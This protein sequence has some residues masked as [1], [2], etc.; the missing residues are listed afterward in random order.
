[1]ND[2]SDSSPSADGAQDRP[3][4]R[5]FLAFSSTLVMGGGVAASYGTLVV[6]AGQYLYPRDKNVSWQFVCTI[7]RLEVGETLDYVTTTGVKV[8]IT[9]QG[10][11][12]TVDDFVALSSTCPHLGCQVHWEPQN[13]RFFCPCHN[14]A[15]DKEGNPTAGPP[16]KDNQQLLR[17]PLKVEGLLLF[18]EAPTTGITD[19]NQSARVDRSSSPRGINA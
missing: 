12:E 9:R 14:G 2:A 17:F 7:D 3:D 16:L 18:V 19:N 8:V 10:E 11:G 5:G 4:R 15:F 13:D 1:M 6:F